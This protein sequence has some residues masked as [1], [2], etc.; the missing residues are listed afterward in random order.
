MLEAGIWNWVLWLG[1]RNWKIDT[2]VFEDWNWLLVLLLRTGIWNWGLAFGTGVCYR[3]R[4]DMELDKNG[5][6]YSKSQPQAPDSRSQVLLPDHSPSLFSK[7]QPQVSA[8]TF[9]SQPP[10]PTASIRSPLPVPDP[11]PSTH[12]H[13]QILAPS[14]KYQTPVPMPAPVCLIFFPPVS[15]ADGADQF[16]KASQDLCSIE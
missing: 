1:Y 15:S 12:P 14:S 9:R 5:D 10:V 7:S 2:G 6:S 16:W 4:W 8:P 11:A 13:F 3:G